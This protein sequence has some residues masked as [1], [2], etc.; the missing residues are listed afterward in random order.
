MDRL[1]D[2]SVEDE[3]IFKEV[4]TMAD[5]EEM[6]DSAPARWPD[7]VPRKRLRKKGPCHR[8]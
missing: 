3:E 6:F 2:E 4:P 7:G 8:R 1:D 5:D